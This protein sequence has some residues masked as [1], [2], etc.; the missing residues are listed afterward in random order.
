MPKILKDSDSPDIALSKFER[1]REVLRQKILSGE[2][3]P[4]T[5]LPTERELPKLLKVGNQTIRRALSEL[6]QEG[7]V[8][9]RRGKGTFVSD[10]PRPH[11]VS[12]RPA[13]IA[14]LW[15]LSV[16]PGM[17]ATTLQGK[18]AQGILKGLGLDYVQPEWISTTDERYSQATVKSTKIKLTVDMLGDTRYG[19]TKHPP[20]KAVEKGAYDGIICCSIVEDEF[21]TAL[22]E[23]GKPTVLVDVL[24][25]TLTEKVDQVF[26]D[27]AKG[28]RKAVEYFAGQGLKRIH[29]VNGFMTKPKPQDPQSIPDDYDSWRMDPDSCLRMSA[30]IQ[31]MQAC[32]LPVSNEWL[33]MKTPQQRTVEELGEML[34]QLPD[35]P[36]AVLTHNV[37]QAETLARI[38][39]QKGLRLEGAGADDDSPM[40]RAWPIQT[41]PLAMGIAAAEI[42]LARMQNP[43]RLPVRAGIPMLFPGAG[44]V[45]SK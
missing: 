25:E 3:A 42:L 15:K 21:L 16:I 23:I 22:L 13:R 4:G 45:Q 27:P 41:T 7:L 9:R 30:Y 1:A 24:N 18:I 5:Q 33:H 12:G 40:V 36:E 28:Y 10:V 19:Q 20:L 14:L 44:N 43:E 34:S 31:G 37:K 11:H 26:F 8:Y 32:G 35:P 38:F 29:F 17:I 6:A 39:A 2:Y